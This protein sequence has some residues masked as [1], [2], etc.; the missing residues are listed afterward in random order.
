MSETI[1]LKGQYEAATVYS[2]DPL[3]AVRDNVISPIECLYLIEL[4]KPHIKRAGV[5]LDDGYKES[6]GRTGSNH[7]LK[8][9]E[10]DVVN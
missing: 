2:S 1:Q 10:D 4:A 5:V 8:Y 6:D 7:W 9:D 3:V